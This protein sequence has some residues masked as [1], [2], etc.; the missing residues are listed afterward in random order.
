M[1]KCKKYSIDLL[2]SVK[3]VDNIINSLESVLLNAGITRR[4][5]EITLRIIVAS[6]VGAIIG[7]EREY[8]QKPIG[9]RTTSIVCM[10]AAILSCYEEMLIYK[11]IAINAELIEQG[12]KTIISTPALTRITAQIVSG[13][14][15]LGAGMILYTRGKVYGITTAATIWATACLGIVIGSGQWLLAFIGFF[16]IMTSLFMFRFFIP[17]ITRKK[18]FISKY[19]IMH[20]HD[21]P[22]ELDLN[23]FGI[24]VIHSEVIKWVQK[25]DSKCPYILS[26]IK[27]ITQSDDDASI[28]SIM[29]FL[30]IRVVAKLKYSKQS[31]SIPDD[32]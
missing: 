27:I 10:A 24:K 22:F 17:F 6:I 15:F 5:I 3:I 2:K 16:G 26:K 1:R 18:N 29:E 28:K 21:N 11:V 9:G 14:G 30:E 20:T 31:F 12:S 4:I 7:M 32:N 23:K 19:V 25:K 8:H 13:I